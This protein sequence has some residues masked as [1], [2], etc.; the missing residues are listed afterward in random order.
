MNVLGTLC[1]VD[2]R[3]Y[4]LGQVGAPSGPPRGWR[5]PPR[6]V[7]R[8]L[9]HLLLA[10]SLLFTGCRSAQPVAKQFQVGWR[11]VASF[12]GR[13]SEQT[14]S[15][16]IES[17]EWRIKWNATGSGPFRVTVHSAVSGRPL[18][19]AVDRV[20]PARGIAY[21]NE[22]PRLYHLVIDAAGGDWS[23]VIEEA[24]VGQ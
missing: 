15:F 4:P 22:D 24:V 7:R 13:A 2:S 17:G 8:P 16:N 5:C 6:P 20:G 21:V 18:L 1:L 23:L 10:G 11:P 12:T 14:E 19:V 3:R 9:E